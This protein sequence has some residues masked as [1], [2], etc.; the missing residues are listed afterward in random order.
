MWKHCCNVMN[1]AADCA[2]A[3]SGQALMAMALAMCLSYTRLPSQLNLQLFIRGSRHDHLT[4]AELTCLTKQCMQEDRS[5]RAYRAA[6]WK[7]DLVSMLPR[8]T[9]NSSRLDSSRLLNT[10]PLATPVC[11]LFRACNRPLQLAFLH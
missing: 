11:F 10:V 7:R 1:T 6:V 3:K 5:Q 2:A 9:P 8:C 4:R